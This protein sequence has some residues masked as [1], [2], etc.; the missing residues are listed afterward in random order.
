MRRVCGELEVGQCVALERFADNMSWHNPDG[1]DTLLS[2]LTSVSNPEACFIIGIEVVFRGPVIRPLPVLNENL[3]RTT[4]A[5]AT[6]IHRLLFDHRMSRRYA[7]PALR[8]GSVHARQLHPRRRSSP[9]SGGLV[10]RSSFRDVVNAGTHGGKAAPPMDEL[11]AIPATCR[12]MRRV[13]RDTEVGRRISVE[14][15]AD[16][17]AWDDPDGYHT[18][19]PRLAQVSNREACFI[20]G[21]HVVFLD[22]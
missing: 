20:T 21:M 17:M 12:F 11:R 18:V 4:A 14:R 2:R 22:L 15:L 1:Y 9:R 13:C 16:D 5:Q 19:L 8:L 3:E 6:V 7:Y 10:S